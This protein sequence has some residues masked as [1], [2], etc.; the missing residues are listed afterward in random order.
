MILTTK[1]LENLVSA[2]YKKQEFERSLSV[3]IEDG[4]AGADIKK[5]A[6]KHQA[7]LEALVK[8]DIERHKNNQ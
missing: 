7:F 2:N 6:D 8:Q 1:Y 5:I 3:T 4:L